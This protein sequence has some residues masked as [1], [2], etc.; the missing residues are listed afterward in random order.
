M[1]VFSSDAFGGSAGTELS[2]YNAAWSKQT[3]D[4]GSAQLTAD[5]RVRTSTNTTAVYQ[6]SDAPA[7]A[8]YDVSIDVYAA[9][10]VTGARA[11]PAG[12]M[13]T[14]ANSYYAARLTG[15][16]G[17][18]LVKVVAG[19]LSQIGSTGSHTSTAGSTYTVKLAM[20]GSGLE[21]FIGGV[22]KVSAS[23]TAITDAG[24]AGI[25]F[26]SGG[27]SGD[28][29]NFHADNFSAEEAGGSSSV[30][31]DSVLRWSLVSAINADA[32]LRYSIV[33]A[34]QQDAAVRWAMLAAVSADVALLWDMAGATGVVSQDFAARWSML[35]PVNADASIHWSLLNAVARD[36]AL[37]WSMVQAI[38]SDR[39]LRWSLIQAVQADADIAWSLVK[40]VSADAVLAWDLASSLGTVGA[41]VSLR[42]SLIAAVQQSIDARWSLLQ[43]V[44]ADAEMRWDLLTSLT[45]ELTA[46]WSMIGRAMADTPIRWDLIAA[47][48]TDLVIR[49]QV[50]EV[51]DLVVRK[52]FV[53]GAGMRRSFVV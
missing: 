32:T 24:R 52:R 39:A 5:G 50:G 7:S 16:S 6:R 33:Q 40:A 29:V 25:Y 22:S 49:W 45:A 42:W 47:S 13:S 31:A 35:A 26:V 34:V 10:I 19:S 17:V 36:V 21:I 20:S 28:S 43:S 27:T 44:G 18:Q 12:R 46:R 2:A 38:A 51:F 41:S 3:G 1:G 53:A 11:G 14:S 23:D 48:A 15:A 37:P 4:T 9:T 8:D 30:N